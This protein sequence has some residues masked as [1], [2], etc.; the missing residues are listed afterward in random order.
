[1]MRI[2]DQ[3]V[4]AQMILEDV[5]AG[6]NRLFLGHL[7]KTICIPGFLGAFDDKGRRFVIKLI[8]VRPNPT[9]VGFLKDKG[10]GVIKFLMRSQPDKLAF[11]G[12]DIRLEMLGKFG[13]GLG[14]QAITGN[15]Q[16][17]FLGIMGSTFGFRLKAQ[18]NTQF[19][20]TFLQQDQKLFATD[21][22]EPVAGGNRLFA[23]ILNRDI[24]PIGKVGANGLGTFAIILGQIVERLVRQHHTPAKC[25]IWLVALNHNN[26]VRGV[27]Q[28]HRDPKVKPRRT[29][30]QT[31]Y[32]HQLFPS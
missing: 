6:C 11:A 8:G 31:S 4:T 18:L 2:A 7:A 12:I 1:M 14:I 5:L 17:E 19:T 26:L 32:S 3:I 21:A 29:A 20:C 15:N 23:A 28:F 27:A 24:I 10:K 25:V 16:I 30:T 22:A 9:L 13:A